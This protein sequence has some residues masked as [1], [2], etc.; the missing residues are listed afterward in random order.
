MTKRAHGKLRIIGGEHRSRLIEFEG[1]TGVRPTPDRVRQ[2]FFDWL[3]PVIEGARCLDLFSGSGALGLEALSRGAGHVT[4]V[5]T[6]PRQSALIKTAL[7]SLNIPHS[8]YDVST[9]DALYFLTQT[10]HR[11]NVVF[12]DPPFGSGLLEK[13][14]EDLAKVLAPLNRI[15]LEWPEDGNKPELPAGFEWLRE[16]QAGQVCFGLATYQTEQS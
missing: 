1:E 12:L 3:M 7:M 13:A 9:V 14:L 15:C 10:W 11:Y 4:F 8:R 6:G 2:T 16:K 5:E